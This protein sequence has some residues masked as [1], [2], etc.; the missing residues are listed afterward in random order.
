VAVVRWV[1]VGWSVGRSVGW[2]V[3][4]MECRLLDA[5]YGFLLSSLSVGLKLVMLPMRRV[6]FFLSRGALSLLFTLPAFCLH[7][8]P[9]LFCEVN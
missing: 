8:P 9:G 1:L 4:V 5:L 3:G 6:F 7:L 2:Q